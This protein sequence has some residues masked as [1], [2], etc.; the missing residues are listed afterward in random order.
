MKLQLGMFNTDG[1]PVAQADVTRMLGSYSRWKAETSGEFMEG[2][3][4]MIYRG[5]QITAEEEHEIQPWR[6]G[7]L[8]LALTWDGRL[9]NREEIA[10]LAGL[11]PL[12]HVPDPVLVARGY[13]RFGEAIFSRLIGEFALVLWCGK[14]RALRFVRSACGTRQL[15]Y[16]FAGKSLLWASDFAHLVRTSGAELEINENYMVEHLVSQPD[17]RH[18]PLASIHVVP[19]NT[20]LRFEDHGV[21]NHGFAPPLQ[22]WDPAAIRPLRYKSDR[23]YEEHCRELLTQ[24]VRVKLRSKHTVF[25]ELSGGL[26]SSSVVVMADH[27]L[28]Q[29]NRPPERLQT[30]SCVFEESESCDEQ[31]FIK[32]VEEQRGIQTVRISEKQQRI[33]TGLREINFTGMPN[34]LHCASGR[35]Q[36]YTSAMK[37][38]GARL[39]LTGAGGDHLFWSAVDAAPLIADYIYQGQFLRMH[40]SCRAWSRSMGVPYMQLLYGQALPRAVAAAKSTIFAREIHPIPA[41]LSDRHKKAYVARL[42]S[43]ES[44]AR[45]LPSMR[46]QLR[47]LKSLFNMTSAGYTSEYRDV[48]VSHP[49]LYRPLVEFCLA[50]PPD[51]FLRNGEGRSLMRRVLSGLL[52]PRILTRKSKG[53]INEAFSRA[54]QKDWELMDDLRQWQL[55]R[56]GFAEP[57]ILQEHLTRSMLGIDPPGS[58]VVRILSAERWLRSLENVYQEQPECSLS[59][60]S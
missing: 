45:V 22:L 16:A 12:P 5:D 53:A 26:D 58:H 56:R 49:F 51:Q 36:A 13:E 28:T 21:E 29:Q 60:A 7:E 38:R 11:A 6:F 24:A 3:L 41:W 39:L 4:L 1:C 34:P 15:F 30:L 10:A 44:R 33:S 18:S 19:P 14:N 27:V 50:V 25:A 43:S 32:A 8:A 57:R 47:D 46:V 2:P 54:L 37:A 17:S 52:P 42:A 23:E 9:D 31:Y 20:M 59:Y 48:Y 55:C 40:R 35:F